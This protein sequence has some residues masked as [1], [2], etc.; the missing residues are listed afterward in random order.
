MPRGRARACSPTDLPGGREEGDGERAPRPLA[1]GGLRALRPQRHRALRPAA[2]VA[3][4]LVLLLLALPPPG[5]S[6]LL[7]P[8]LLFLDQDLLPPLP[9]RQFDAAVRTRSDTAPLPPSP[10]LA[11]A[12]SGAAGSG[13]PLNSYRVAP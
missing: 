7:P 12:R 2:V 3:L 6:L 5:L 1:E 4:L 13:T 10:S 11:L 9:L 8:P